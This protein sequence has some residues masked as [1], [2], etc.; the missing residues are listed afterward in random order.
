MLFVVSMRNANDDELDTFQPIG[1]AADKLIDRL[2]K[3]GKFTQSGSGSGSKNSRSLLNRGEGA[4]TLVLPI[5]AD[6]SVPTAVLPAVNTFESRCGARAAISKIL[7]FRRLAQIAKSVVILLA[8]DVVYHIGRPPAGHV[9]PRQTVSEVGNAIDDDYSVSYR[10]HLPGRRA[11]A[12]PA[13][14]FASKDASFGVV[15]KFGN[16]DIPR[17]QSL[18]LAHSVFGFHVNLILNKLRNATQLTEAEQPG[19][20]RDDSGATERPAKNEEPR[21]ALP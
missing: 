14:A 4:K 15:R 13:L 20:Q 8:I 19:Q 2:T 3:S 6:F 5:K 16:N 18:F 11:A 10:L 7:P 17:E 21:R 12:A 1:L 9:Q